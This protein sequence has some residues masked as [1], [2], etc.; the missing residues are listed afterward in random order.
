MR[1]LPKGENLLKM[2]TLYGETQR[3]LRSSVADTDILPILTATNLREMVR[4][5]IV[6]FIST[7]PP[8]FETS[9]GRVPWKSLGVCYVRYSSDLQ[10]PRSLDDQLLK[11]LSR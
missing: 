6:K 3:K 5:Y 9:P 10:N 1:G 7:S 11:S 2:A 4:R 8:R